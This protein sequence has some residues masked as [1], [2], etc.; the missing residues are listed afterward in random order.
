MM[1]HLCTAL[2]M[3]AL[4]GAASQTMADEP[5]ANDQPADT[6]SQQHQ[7]HQQRIR[8][9]GEKQSANDERVHGK[10]KGGE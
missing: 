1:N 6:T 2:V 10:A 5:P 9:T 3:T 4:L 8:R 7:Q